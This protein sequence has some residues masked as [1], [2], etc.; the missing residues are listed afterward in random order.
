MQIVA[1]H[2][3]QHKSYFRGRA[4]KRGVDVSRMPVNLAPKA[5]KFQFQ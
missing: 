5:I 4:V 1:S 2:Q 3:S